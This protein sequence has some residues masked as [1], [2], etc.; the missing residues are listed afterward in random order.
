MVQASRKWQITIN[1]PI[2]HG[3]TRE[4]IK[5]I[6]AKHNTAYWAIVDEIGEKGTPHVHIFIYT[7]SPS[8]FEMWKR[9]FDGCAHIE[10]ARGSIQENVAYLRKEGKW[11]GTE[12][13]DTTIEGS[14]EEFGAL[15]EE[16]GQG[17]RSDIALL[18]TLVEQGM[19]NAELM[20]AIPEIYIRNI[21][22]VDR[23]RLNICKE[24]F[25]EVFRQLEVTYIFGATGRG[26][27][28]YVMEKHGYSKTYRVVNNKNP[29]DLYEMEDVIVFEEFQS[30]QF[31]M[32]EMLVWLDGYPCS[33]RCRYA[34]KIAA[35]TIVYLLSNTSLQLQYEDIQEQNYETFKAFLRRIHHVIEYKENGEIVDYGTGMQYIE[36]VRDFKVL[37]E[38]T[39]SPFS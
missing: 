1:N 19:T 30:K 27:T 13:S 11:K 6:M 17:Y 28:R 21:G 32:S 31:K 20:R 24:Q 35:Y 33:L 26:K 29:F 36:S 14:Y 18:I 23:M 2:E 4:R 10:N 34:D 12:K 15:P 8:K 9:E 7:H 38:G 16:K 39:L 22:A 37:P 25:S 5:K 3:F